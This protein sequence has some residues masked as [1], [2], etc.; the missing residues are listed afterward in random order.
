MRSHLCF[1]A[2]GPTRDKITLT[3]LSVYLRT[4]VHSTLDFTFGYS[5]YA[6]VGKYDTETVTLPGG[7][8]VVAESS[9][10]IGLGFWTHQL[11]Q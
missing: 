5:F 7:A 8:T 10:N 3:S 1:S 9:D 6:P 4:N 11:A 2:T